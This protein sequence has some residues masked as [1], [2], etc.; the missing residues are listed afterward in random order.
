M[1]CARGCSTMPGSFRAAMTAAGFDLLPG[2]HPIIPVMLGE[3][4]ARPGHGGQAL[5]R[6]GIYVT[7]FFYPVVPQGKARIRTQM[8][9]AHCARRCRRGGR[10]L[11]AGRP[12]RWE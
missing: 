9:A 2:E 10:G 7:G 3:R 12:R 5:M 1:I 4:E 8:S 11:H 6:A